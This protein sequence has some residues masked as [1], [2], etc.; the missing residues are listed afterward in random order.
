V[1]IY[2]PL[3]RAKGF[4]RT[5]LGSCTPFYGENPARRYGALDIYNPA[6][7]GHKPFVNAH[8]VRQNLLRAESGFIS[9]THSEN[10]APVRL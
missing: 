6:V 2:I 10:N 1:F 3:V 8:I 9:S 4:W 7:V 5:L